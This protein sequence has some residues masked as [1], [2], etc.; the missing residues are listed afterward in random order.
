MRE[1]MLRHKVVSGLFLLS[2]LLAAGGA[3]WAYVALS[4]VKGP[5]IIGFNGGSIHVGDLGHLMAVG[6][7]AAIVVVWNFIVGL[8]LDARDRFL[9]KLL[10][11]ATLALAFLIFIAFAA[12]I[13]VN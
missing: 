3:A 7:T 8:E 9:G 12:I 4:G 6:V 1:K 10:A 5:L 2:F 11:A 13:S